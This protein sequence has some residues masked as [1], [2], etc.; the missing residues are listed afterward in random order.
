[1][2]FFPQKAIYVEKDSIQST[3]KENKHKIDFFFLIL[4]FC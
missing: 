3:G 2:D 4:I 1:M